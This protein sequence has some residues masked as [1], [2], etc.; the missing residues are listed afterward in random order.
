MIAFSRYYLGREHRITFD[1]YPVF[2]LIEPII[3]GIYKVVSHYKIAQYKEIV[4]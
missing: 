2:G 3:Y 4:L 1:K